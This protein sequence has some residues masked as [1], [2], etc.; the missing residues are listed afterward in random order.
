MNPTFEQLKSQF[1]QKTSAPQNNKALREIL[2]VERELSGNQI[3]LEFSWPIAE[4][5]PELAEEKLSRHGFTG[6]DY[7]LNWKL[8][9]ESKQ[10]RLSLTNTK[11]GETRLLADCPAPLQ[12]K[13]Y[14][15]LSLFVEKLASKANQATTVQ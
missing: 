8:V 11:T 6:R 14:P 4:L 5:S 9:E 1:G 10:Y 13:F 15:L 2:Y 7:L 3:A 12:E